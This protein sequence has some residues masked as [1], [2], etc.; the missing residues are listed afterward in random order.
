[1]KTKLLSIASALSLLIIAPTP[2]FA[3]FS[4][5]QGGTGWGN[6]TSGALLY[7]NGANPLATTSAGILGQVLEFN[8]S[9]P[10]WVS[11]SSL[12]ISASAGGSNGQVQFNDGGKLGGDVSLTF[13]TSSQTLT[14][15]TTTGTRQFKLFAAD[16]NGGAGVTLFLS[17]GGG[18]SATAAGGT[19]A[20]YGGAGNATAGATSGGGEVDI[21]GGPGGDVGN[22]GFAQLLGGAGGV[23]SGNGGDALVASGNALSSSG[24]G[25]NVRFEASCNSM[26]TNCGQFVF[27]NDGTVANG[28]L[29]FDQLSSTDKVFT[30]PNFSG[31]LG[32][33]EIDQTWSGTNTFSKGAS[34]T[35]TVDFGTIG[36]ATS[37]ACFNTKDAVTGG[38]VSFYI[39]NG[40]M[41]VEN[42]VCR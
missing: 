11:T 6:F 21:E 15:G 12:G 18:G 4:V 33:L 19:I 41:V 20:V 26:G 38:D 8:G 35:T 2:A 34:A 10:T 13:S 7:G 36:D 28:I 29:K 30:F 9:I 40:A 22:G 5:G 37:R 24:A 31:T 32:L 16:G 42:N 39:A 25:G 3:L 14:V 23:S 1:M 27:R 17:G